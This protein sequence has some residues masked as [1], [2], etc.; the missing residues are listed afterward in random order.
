V[1]SLIIHYINEGSGALLERNDM[2]L[3]QHRI[4]VKDRPFRSSTMTAALSVQ[5]AETF[6]VSLN[7]NAS[8]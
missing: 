2:K 8:I 3:E 5:I 1:S 4:L 7:K 6:A